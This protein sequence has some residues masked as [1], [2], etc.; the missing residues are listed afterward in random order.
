MFRRF[1]R[2]SSILDVLTKQKYRIDICF[3]LPIP[4]NYI[5]QSDDASIKHIENSVGSI[6]CVDYCNHAIS[7]EVYHNQIIGPIKKYNVFDI[8]IPINKYDKYYNRTNLVLLKELN[9]DM[10]M[11]TKKFYDIMPKY[12]AGFESC[13]LKDLVGFYIVSYVQ[14]DNI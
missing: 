9:L 10:D 12:L 6:M 14:N 5:I 13:K 11:S 1:Y 8:N 2:N 3:G 4:K 7:N